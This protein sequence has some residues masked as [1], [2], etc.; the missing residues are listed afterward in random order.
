MPVVFEQ[1]SSPKIGNYVPGTKIEIIPD[2]ELLSRAG[3][4]IIVW[5]WHIAPEVV[6]YLLEI[7]YKGEVWVPLPEFKLFTTID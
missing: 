4:R 3:N 6:S 5:A 1:I 7:G 2:S